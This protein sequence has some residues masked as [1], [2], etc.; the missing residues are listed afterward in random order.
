MWFHSGFMGPLGCDQV[1]GEAGME[2]FLLYELWSSGRACM[3]IKGFAHD[4]AMPRASWSRQM[5]CGFFLIFVSPIQFSL[6][7]F[8]SAQLSSSQFMSAQLSST[9]FSSAQFNRAQFRSAHVN[10]IQFNSAQF[11]SGQPSGV[12]LSPAQHSSISSIQFNSVQL[13]KA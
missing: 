8:S 5:S 11:S 9:M 1:G 10:S 13:S 2:M 12:Q 6:G 7:H 4:A 3:H